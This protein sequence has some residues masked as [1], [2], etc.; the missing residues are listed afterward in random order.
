MINTILNFSV[1][2]HRCILRNLFVIICIPLGGLISINTVSAQTAIWSNPINGTVS[3][4]NAYISGQTVVSNLNVSG[5]SRVGATAASASGAY[6]ATAWPSTTSINTGYYFEFTLTPTPGYEIALSQFEFQG[7]RHSSGPKKFSLRSSVDNFST[8]IGSISDQNGT[9]EFEVT[10]SLSGAAY[11]NIFSEPITFRLY[12][13]NANSNANSS[14]RQFQVNSFS[15]TGEVVEQ[16]PAIYRN[17]ILGSTGN[18]SFNTGNVHDSHVTVGSIVRGG[19]LSSVS[20]THR[21]SATGWQTNSSIVNN[22]YFQFDI[23]P[24]PGYIINF[25]T[26]NFTGSRNTNGPRSFALRTSLDNFNS[27][28]GSISN[29]TN[30]SAFEKNVDMTGISANGTI[31]IRL[32][33]YNASSTSSPQL[34]IH[35][36]AFSGT[37]TPLSP[38]SISSFYPTNGC[39]IYGESFTITGSDFNF[40]NDVKL[41][42]VSVPYNVLNTSQIQVTVAEGT[43]SGQISV[44]CATGTATSNDVFTVYDSGYDTLVEANFDNNSLAEWTSSSSNAFTISSSSPISGTHSLNSSSSNWSFFSSDAVS[45]YTSRTITDIQSL[46]NNNTIWRFNSRMQSSASSFFFGD[47][48]SDV[49]YMVAVDNSNLQSNGLNGYAIRFRHLYE[50][51][52]FGAI[53]SY[54]IGLYKIQNGTPQ[55]IGSS[56]NLNFNATTVGVELSR[57]AE[58]EWTLKL[59]NNGGF[60]NLVTRSTVTDTQ[61]TEL[62]HFGIRTHLSSGGFWSD[63]SATLRFDDLTI[64]QGYCEEVYYSQ[65]NDN[66]HSSIWQR[67]RQG[68]TAL[69]VNNNPRAS[70]VVQAG[71]TITMSN[72]WIGKNFIVEP[73]GSLVIADSKSLSL[74]G[75]LDVQGSFNAGTGSVIFIG[76]GAQE[77]RATS[78]L[79]L[80]DLVLD[81]QSTLNFPDNVVTNIRPNGRLTINSGNINT[82]DNLVLRSTASGTGSIG[83]IADGSVVNGKVTQERF[84]PNMTAPA[85]VGNGSWI[86]VGTPLLGATVAQWDETVVTTGFT[87]SN[88]PA[89][90][91]NFNNIQWYNESLPGGLGNGYVGVSHINE[92]LKPNKGY[93]FYTYANLPSPQNVLRAKGN[94]QQGAFVD[95]VYYTPSGNP[96]ADGWNLLVNRYPSEVDFKAMAEA[97]TGNIRTYHLFDAE[98]N[99]YKVYHTASVGTAPQYIA[100]GQAY[101]VKAEAPG[102]TLQYRETFKSRAGVAFERS[103]TEASYAAIRFFKAANSSDECVINFNADATG[104]YEYDFDAK[105]LLSQEAGAAE[106]ALVSEDGVRLTIDSR[107]LNAEGNIT[108]PVFVKMPNSGTYRLRIEEVNNLPLGTCLMIEDLV[109]GNVIPFV[110]GQ[111]FVISHTGN[112]SGNRFLIHATPSIET[113]LANI[114]CNNANNGSISLDVP[115]GE[116]NI[117]LTDSL[118]QAYTAEEGSYTFNNLPAQLYTVT[119]TPLASGC[120]TTSKTIELSE[121][122]AVEFEAL[123]STI[124]FC[125][126]SESG[127]IAW[128]VTNAPSYEFTVKNSNDEIVSSGTANSGMQHL[129]GLNADVY[130]VTLQAYCG[131]QEFVFDL[132]DYNVVDAEI[133]SDDIF[134]ALTE[135]STQALTI[136]QNNTN[137]TNFQWTLSNGFVSNESEFNYEF[138]EAGV[139]TLTLVANSETCSATDSIEIVVDRAVSI[140]EL[141]D[142]SSIAV[143]QTSGSLEVYLNFQSSEKT[144]VTVYDINGKVISKITTST[145]KGKNISVGTGG[146]ATG[147]YIL[148]VTNSNEEL[149]NKKFINP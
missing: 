126:S 84:L 7:Q 58:G 53:N 77:I 132:H 34:H 17:P 45:A 10:I 120:I 131:S 70:F 11:Q 55:L 91:Y 36:F 65:G 115:Q 57:T 68:M 37:V 56:Y 73:A 99:N 2:A 38:P 74:H 88:Y 27:N 54:S 63:V 39:A 118:G 35:D 128:Q 83:M 137:A 110:A 92:A 26:F 127:V 124:D 145:W 140:T 125:N 75:D 106:C 97:G 67:E 111:E 5:I 80:Y 66:A 129:N 44:I 47:Y 113:T 61:F 40:V 86:A 93:F 146:L 6:S 135:G 95:T 82:N 114:D 29:E 32:Y 21:Y 16:E 12:A 107:P 100:S 96:D 1:N 24:T 123:N 147:M 30:T 59:D 139:Y 134:F 130:T 23:T 22:D 13:W 105:K 28:V 62:N 76:H 42:G 133:L 87:G 31:T 52:L 85:L 43:S 136:E 46:E 112:Y 41:N 25:E 141:N 109:T 71:D 64:S 60:D 79:N 116:W 90:G 4:T 18:G 101:F 19:G 9:G 89:P 3:S 119:A 72:N 94:I 15:F 20:G 138:S 48:T 117:T 51:F 104:N 98:T 49:Y 69:A 14:N 148:Q 142:E 50:Y 78:T 108:I 103:E 143:L 144:T 122:A 81:N 102:A 149:L 8:S 33:G 121:P